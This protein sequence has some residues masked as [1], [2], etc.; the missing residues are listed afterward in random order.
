MNTEL[1]CDNFF[2]LHNRLTRYGCVKN[3]SDPED[4]ASKTLEKALISQFS[5]TAEHFYA[6]VFTIAHNKMVDSHRKSSKMSFYDLDDLDVAVGD[7]TEH[8]DKAIFDLL[9]S[10]LSYFDYSLLVL[11]HVEGLGMDELSTIFNKTE[12]TLRVSLHRAAKRAK[13]VLERHFL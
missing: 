13:H 11:R 12:A 1:L 7:D 2:D 5:G 3:V 8:L 6:Y 9:K 4:F 10:E